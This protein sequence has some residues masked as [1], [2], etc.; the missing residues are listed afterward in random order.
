MFR[1]LSDCFSNSF[2][3]MPERPV[4]VES[5]ESGETSPGRL[6]LGMGT[7]GARV[8]MESWLK[9]IAHSVYDSSL[10]RSL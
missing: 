9:D 1:N 2:R 5:Y 3:I 4:R 7:L 6:T 8:A 10:S